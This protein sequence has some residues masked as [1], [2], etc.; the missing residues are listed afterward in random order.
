MISSL[1]W[2]YLSGVACVV[3]ILEWGVE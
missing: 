3:D 2:V 1:T